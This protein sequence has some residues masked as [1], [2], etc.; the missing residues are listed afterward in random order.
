MASRSRWSKRSTG[1]C[2]GSSDPRRKSVRVT[3]APLELGRALF[4]LSARLRWWRFG[5]G[6]RW[7]KRSRANQECSKQAQHE[8]SEPTQQ[9]RRARRARASARYEHGNLP[10]LSQRV[11]ERVRSRSA[12]PGA[13]QQI[14]R[15]RLRVALAL[16]ELVRRGRHFRVER[17]RRRARTLCRS[18]RRS[19]RDASRGARHQCNGFTDPPCRSRSP[20]RQG[21]GER[22]A[23][24]QHADRP[25]HEPRDGKHPAT[26]RPERA[27][28]NPR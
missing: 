1:I 18:T 26:L 4:D 17:Y 9:S 10:D 28:G 2:T 21:R 20:R 22:D 5:L 13:I 6:P 25:E 14:P 16:N 12:E 3:P 27:T 15:S 11:G 19:E 8:P 23:E 7:T 24:E